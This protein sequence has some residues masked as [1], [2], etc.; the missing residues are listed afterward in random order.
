MKFLQISD[1]HYRIHY[2]KADQGYLSIFS[3]MTSPLENIRRGLEQVPLHEL[4]FILICGDLTENGT[5]EDYRHLKSELEGMF[6]SVP[7][8]VTLGNHDRKDEFYLGWEGKTTLNRNYPYGSISV[9]ERAVVIS[10]DNSSEENENGQITTGHCRWLRERL[11]EADQWKKKVILMMHHPLIYDPQTPIPAVGYP[12]EF[13][14]LIRLYRPDAILC[15]HTH[16]QLTGVF[17]DILYATCGS[18][19]FKGEN[20][21]DGTVVF[22]ERGGMNLFTAEDQFISIQE[23]AVPG[24]GKELG[25]VKM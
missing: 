8:V 23:I 16:N 24:E 14:R 20:R 25:R 15:G 18:M 12:K 6:G 11:A 5:E 1:L 21:D 9:F 2:P 4:D 13:V 22:R 10:M 19:S 3:Q 7:Y 17:E